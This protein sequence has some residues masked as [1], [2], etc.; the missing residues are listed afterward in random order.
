MEKTKNLVLSLLL[1]FVPLCFFS[2]RYPGQETNRG[3]LVLFGMIAVLAMSQNKQEH[4]KLDGVGVVALLL[5]LIS[6]VWEPN[7]VAAL[8]QNIMIFVGI[9]FAWRLSVDSSKETE[10]CILNA[11]AI[12]C[13]IQSGLCILDYF[14][15]PLYQRVIAAIFNLTE[16]EGIREELARETAGSLGGVA[17]TGGYIALT[18]VGLIRRVAWPLMAVAIFAVWTTGSTMAMV[19]MLGI[20]GIYAWGHI[21]RT[22][23]SK[24]T[25]VLRGL[26]WVA[27]PAIFLGLV[28]KRP[29]F[30]RALQNER[31]ENW[32][33]IVKVLKLH[34]TTEKVLFGHGAGWW[35]DVGKPASGTAFY[36]EHNEP[37]S[38]FIAFGVGGLV[39]GM[40]FMVRIGITEAKG[41]R[42]KFKAA[43]FAA[44]VM[45]FGHFVM[46]Q[47][48]A[49]I[50]VLCSVG[51]FL[52]PKGEWDEQ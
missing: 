48:T 49:A 26:P 10:E 19:G 32:D 41:N 1:L 30:F 25:W 24:W 50:V 38:L 2:S 13:L 11:M 36:W 18:S 47:G 46:H 51:M 27:M 23:S 34:A 16:K 6:R 28:I 17:R 33:K 35:T 14:G 52:R 21:E 40:L 42:M 8:Y 7:S 39:L 37:L 9:L 43:I 29:G 22:A 12:G 31:L 5:F 3:N 4:R 45:S 20:A 44:F 15:F